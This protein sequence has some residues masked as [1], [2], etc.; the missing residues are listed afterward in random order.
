MGNVELGNI[1]S[2]SFTCLNRFAVDVVLL[3]DILHELEVNKDI[4]F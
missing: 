1:V 4:M 2:L 3:V